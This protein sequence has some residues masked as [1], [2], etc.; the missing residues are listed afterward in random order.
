VQL[1]EFYPAGWRKELAAIGEYLEEFGERAPA[2]LL[3]EQ[4]RVAA[5][6]AEPALQPG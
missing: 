1:L 5:A 4:R 3:A 6:L 2:A